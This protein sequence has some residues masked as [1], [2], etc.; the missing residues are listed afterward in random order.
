MLGLIART[1]QCAALSVA[2]G[3]G[4][5]QVGCTAA[6]LSPPGRAGH[7]IHQDLT[8]D[9]AG[10]GRSEAD[11]SAITSNLNEVDQ[12]LDSHDDRLQVGDTWQLQDVLHDLKQKAA[13]LNRDRPDSI[14]IIRLDSKR[15]PPPANQ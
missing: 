2:G 7:H 1:S 13:Q 3:G 10:R 5:T 9:V 11:L 12:W 4:G 8:R 6:L 14:N 15:T